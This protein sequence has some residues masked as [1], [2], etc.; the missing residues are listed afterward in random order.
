VSGHEVILSHELRIELVTA[1]NELDVLD[2]LARKPPARGFEPDE[3]GPEPRIAGVG[4]KLGRAAGNRRVRGWSF[5]VDARTK[6]GRPR[7]AVDQPRLEPAEAKR[8][9][10]VT[11]A[12]VRSRG[13]GLSTRAGRSG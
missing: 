10:E 11:L 5:G 7:V 8:E 3:L 9:L 2:L 13:D 6:L 4:E 12:G 1:A